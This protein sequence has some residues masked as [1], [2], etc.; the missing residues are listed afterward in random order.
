M[1]CPVSH[2]ARDH[3]TGF[4]CGESPNQAWHSIVYISGI[5][6][7]VSRVQQAGCSIV[8]LVTGLFSTARPAPSCTGL[9]WPALAGKQNNSQNS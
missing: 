3:R 2:I 1:P 9:H 8:A 7:S 4:A 5:L 6:Y